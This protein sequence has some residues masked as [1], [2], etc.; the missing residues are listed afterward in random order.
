M[1]VEVHGGRTA[2]TVYFGGV[3]VM[4]RMVILL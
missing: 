3:Y 4:C 1:A 2:D